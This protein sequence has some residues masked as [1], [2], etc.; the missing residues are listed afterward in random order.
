MATKVKICGIT[1]PADALLALSLGADY[2][3]IIVHAKSPRAVDPKNIPALL[4]HI[5]PGKRVLVDVSTPTDQLERYLE[6]GFD[7]YQIHFDLEVSMATVAAWSGLVGQHALWAAPRIP[8]AEKHFPQVLMEFA[9]TILLDAYDPKVYGGTGQAG[10]N[11]Q[12]FLDCTLYY[13]HKRWILAGGLS[14]DNIAEAL[15]FTSAEMVDVNSGVESVPGIKDPQRLRRLFEVIREQD[16][17]GA[18]S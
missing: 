5:P 6:L 2:L 14:P 13:Q 7:A 8:P 9:D 1:R 17:D 16:H 11:W 4:E 12:R 3:G 18:G 15:R 10:G